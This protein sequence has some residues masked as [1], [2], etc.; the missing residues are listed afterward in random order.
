MK[1]D[2]DLIRTEVLK[3]KGIGDVKAEQIVEV[4]KNCL[5]NKEGSK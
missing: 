5:K 1:P 3:I 4:V 2:Y